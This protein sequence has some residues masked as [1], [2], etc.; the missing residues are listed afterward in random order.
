MIGAINQELGRIAGTQHHQW[1]IRN[2][3]NNTIPEP[4]EFKP[5]F[6]AGI[7]YY[8]KKVLCN[9]ELL[10]TYKKYLHKRLSGLVV[11]VQVIPYSIY[12]LIL[13]SPCL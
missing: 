8:S 11:V 3:Y 13:P 2:T 12:S 6:M 4:L 9:L 7:E 10:L 1:G 5:W